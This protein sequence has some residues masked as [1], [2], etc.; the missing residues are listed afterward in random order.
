[1]DT[2]EGAYDDPE[3]ISLFYQVGSRPVH[4]WLRWKELGLYIFS[5]KHTKYNNLVGSLS[6][7]LNFQREVLIETKPAGS[8]LRGHT[9]KSL[10]SILVSKTPRADCL[11]SLAIL[12]SVLGLSARRGII[13][14]N[15]V[16]V[17][18]NGATN[19][20]SQEVAATFLKTC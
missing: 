7:K 6:S 15:Q 2:R 16:C 17:G 18:Q 12:G 5:H 19:N 14:Q 20:I 8:E 13:S 4:W 10:I 3:L 1:M 11:N 9:C